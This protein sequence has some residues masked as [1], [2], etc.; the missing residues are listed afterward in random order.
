MYPF[1]LR[2]I[3]FLEKNW[4]PVVSII[5]ILW[6]IGWLNGIKR[7]YQKQISELQ[8]TNVSL[9]T[10]IVN[11][12]RKD[13]LSIV[14]KAEE[15]EALKGILESQTKATLKYKDLYLHEKAA[16]T[17]TDTTA[18]VKFEQDTKCY[19]IKG[20][21]L[22]NLKTGKSGYDLSILPKPI[23]LQIDIL[24]IKEG[25]IYGQVR[26]NIDCLKI[27]KVKFSVSP[28][29]QIIKYQTNWKVSGV[30]FIGGVVLGYF[31]H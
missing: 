19:F 5:L 21:T 11:R 17:I 31:L 28:N 27:D 30:L 6:V 4:K 15:V 24:A 12:W 8:E 9:K 25:E 14:Q 29:I 22:A 16:S 26:P 1:L 20:W 18:M 23:N 13:S 2:S 3:S 10:D 7:R